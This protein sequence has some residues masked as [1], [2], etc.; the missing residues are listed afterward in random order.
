MLK[1]KI[2]NTF[3]EVIDNNTNHVVCSCYNIIDNSQVVADNYKKLLN[4]LNVNF[5]TLDCRT[6]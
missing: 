6:S 4:F 5:E 3:V 2:A 1:I